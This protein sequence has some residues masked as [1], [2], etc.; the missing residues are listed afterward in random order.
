MD[1]HPDLRYRRSETMLEARLRGARIAY[2]SRMKD[3]RWE[4]RCTGDDYPTWHDTQDEALREMAQ[5]SRK[6]AWSQVRR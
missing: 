1:R 5:W 6:Y 3:G 2:A 4:L